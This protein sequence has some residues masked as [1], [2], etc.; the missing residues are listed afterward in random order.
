MFAT[1]LVYLYILLGFQE[2]WV[3]GVV[4]GY[5]LYVLFFQTVIFF[6]VI[7]KISRDWDFFMSSQGLFSSL[8]MVIHLFGYSFIWLCL[9]RIE[10]YY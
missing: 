3:L 10:I 7:F 6:H 9:E 8:H 1:V 4:E 5:S 2:N